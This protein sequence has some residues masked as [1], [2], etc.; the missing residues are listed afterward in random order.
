MLKN[1]RNHLKNPKLTLSNND[2]KVFI[3]GK[4]YTKLIRKDKEQVRL[5]FLLY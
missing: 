5:L 1:F 2:F 3:F 4:N